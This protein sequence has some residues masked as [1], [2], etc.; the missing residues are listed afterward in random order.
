M[1]MKGHTLY[2]PFAVILFVLLGAG[3]AHADPKGLWLA[4]DGAHVRVAKCSQ[5]LC[6]TI[7]AA[8]SPVDPE[9]GQPWTDKNN[10]D[11]AERGRPLVGVTVLYNMVPDGPG[12]WSGTLYNTDDGHTYPG[13]LLDIDPRTIRIEGCALGICGGKNLS[14]IQ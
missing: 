7:A 13:H 12:K 1:M 11:P 10:P 14:R 9:T 3:T 2:N 6:A 5:A 4:Q 8:K